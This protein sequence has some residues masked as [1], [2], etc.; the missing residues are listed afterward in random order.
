M[1]IVVTRGNYHNSVYKYESASSCVAVSEDTPL[2][3]DALGNP[4]NFGRFGNI[5]KWDITLYQGEG[6]EILSNDLFYIVDYSNLNV[7]RYYDMILQEG[8]I[9][10]SRPSRIQITY[11][12]NTESNEILPLNKDGS[13]TILYGSYMQLFTGNMTESTNRVYVNSYDSTYGHIY[14]LDSDANTLSLNGVKYAQFFKHSNDIEYITAGDIVDVAPTI[15]EGNAVWTDDVVGVPNGNVELAG[16]QDFDGTPGES[17]QLVLLMYQTLAQENG[18][19]RMESDAN[20]S[21]TVDNVVYK[22]DDSKDSYQMIDGKNILTGYAWT[23]STSSSET[24]IYTRYRCPKTG[25]SDGTDGDY[26]YTNSDCITG[27][28]SISSVTLTTWTRSGSYDE[29]GDFIGKILFVQYG[30]VNGRRNFESLANAGGSLLVDP[31]SDR[32]NNYEGYSPL[33]FSVEKPILLFSQKLED[34][35]IM[36]CGNTIVSDNKVIVDKITLTAGQYGIKVEGGK[37]TLIKVNSTSDN[38]TTIDLGLSTRSPQYFYV[39]DGEKNGHSV[40]S[41]DAESNITLHTNELSTAEVLINTATRTYVTPYTNLNSLMVL[42]FKNNYITYADDTISY[43][44]TVDKVNKTLWYITHKE[45]KD[46]LPSYNYLNQNSNIPY[47]YKLTSFYR[48]SDENPFYFYENPY[49]NIGSEQNIEY[50]LG[51]QVYTSNDTSIINVINSKSGYNINNPAENPEFNK[52]FSWNQCMQLL[53]YKPTSGIVP[54]Q[55]IQLYDP[56]TKGTIAINIPEHYAG[57]FQ[58]YGGTT[59]STTDTD[60]HSVADDE[61]INTFG[62][63]YLDNYESVYYPNNSSAPRAP[64]DVLIVANDLQE[65]YKL[66]LIGYYNQQQ[67]AS[68]ENYRWVISKPVFYPGTFEDYS[69]DLDNALNYIVSEEVLQD[70]GTK[71]DKE[72]NVNFYG[73]FSPAVDDQIHTEP[74]LIRLIVEDDL[75]NVVEKQQLI[76]VDSAN[77]SS[78]D[79]YLKQFTATINCEDMCVDLVI[80]PRWCSTSNSA[81]T[82]DTLQ[83]FSVF[84]REY[85]KYVKEGGDIKNPQDIIEVVGNQWY[86]VMLNVLSEDY[87]NEQNSLIY[88]KDFNVKNGYSYQ[89]VIFPNLSSDAATSIMQTPYVFANA[90]IGSAQFVYTNSAPIDI[91]WQYWSIVNLIQADNLI[92]APIIDKTYKADTSNIWIFKFSTESG[93]VSQTLAKNSFTTLG[94]YD[95]IGQGTTNYESGS[96]SSYLGF[97]I[98]PSTKSVYLERLM[99]SRNIPLTTNEKMAMLQA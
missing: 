78:Y 45:L 34:Y 39:G 96:I 54:A 87:L 13:S 41:I 82:G 91:N 99:N 11:R 44:L 15:T 69:D 46:P 53:Q 18:V 14:P 89:Y 85:H 32:Y 88:I 17:G 75:G 76:T 21:I 52:N 77:I 26:A 58:H 73:L 62:F 7:S 57:S 97:E 16:I 24:T 66:N 22:R 98:A 80:D 3:V 61:V 35:N 79:K 36:A 70:T 28:K 55:D 51:T 68:W 19:Y 40:V 84:R 59:D 43:Y 30:D 12:T 29:W 2:W 60:F 83:S 67:G 63:L 23:N 42:Q 92:D 94:T 20:S 64:I 49:I 8:T 27:Q 6:S 9:L 47:T 25:T 38:Y 50:E 65:G 93:S 33:Y 71:F 4:I 86:P 5:Y 74:Y 31:Y 56:A 37:G 72:I 95:K 1:V 48:I 90:G 81:I 10:G